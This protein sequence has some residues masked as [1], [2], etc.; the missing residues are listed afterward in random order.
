MEA[1]ALVGCPIRIHPEL[2]VV[3]P[4]TLLRIYQFWGFRSRG[5]Y[6]VAA[7]ACGGV[8]VPHVEIG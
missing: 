3:R 2:M 7:A 6:A 4:K 5:Q 8:Q 1:G